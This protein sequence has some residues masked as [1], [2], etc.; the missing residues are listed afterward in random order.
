V[1]PVGPGLL[2]AV[3]A[4]H[5]HRA[6]NPLAHG[7]PARARLPPATFAVHTATRDVQSGRLPY[8]VP[9]PYWI[10]D[11]GGRP[12]RSVVNHVG[13]TDPGAHARHAAAGPLPRPGRGGAYGRVTAPVVINAGMLTEGPSAARWDAGRAAAPQSELVRL[14]EGPVAGFSRPRAAETHQGFPALNPREAR[15]CGAGGRGGGVNLRRR[16]RCCRLGRERPSQRATC[17]SS[18][19][20]AS[21]ARLRTSCSAV[22]SAPDSTSVAVPAR[23]SFRRAVRCVSKGT[24]C[25][26]AAL[27]PRAGRR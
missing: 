4:A 22:A 3:V 8:Q 9:T 21:N 23:A 16:M 12:V 15:Q 25:S 26:V 27:G 1:A 13:D 10:F 18:L 11:E 7:A 19:P 6:R 2:L 5:R 14:P 20:A 17:A 24:G